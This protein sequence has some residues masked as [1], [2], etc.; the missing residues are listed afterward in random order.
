MGLNKEFSII[1]SPR[2]FLVKPIY[3]QLRQWVL[4]VYVFLKTIVIVTGEVGWRTLFREKFIPICGVFL[5]F[6]DSLGYLLGGQ[7]T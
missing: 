3:T 7:F 5:E 1:K 2:R 6:S 4:V